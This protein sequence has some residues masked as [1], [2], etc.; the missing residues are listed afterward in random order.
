MCNADRKELCTKWENK[1]RPCPSTT[2]EHIS[3]F[4]EIIQ[5]INIFNAFVI[6]IG[7]HHIILGSYKGSER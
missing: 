3:L 6:T 4:S 2:T 5:S 7:K 1:L